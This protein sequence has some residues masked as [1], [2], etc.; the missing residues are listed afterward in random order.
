MILQNR[1]QNEN[2]NI[3]ALF[4]FSRYVYSMLRALLE[5]FKYLN[6]SDLIFVF[7]FALFIWTSFVMLPF[8]EA[9]NFKFMIKDLKMQYSHW[10][11]IFVLNWRTSLQYPCCVHGRKLNPI[12]AFMHF[13][14]SPKGAIS[15]NFHD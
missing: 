6:R 15:K 13:C 14:S 12:Y 10:I 4:K 11:V 1:I 3:R 9:I 5:L 2:I 7:A 8:S